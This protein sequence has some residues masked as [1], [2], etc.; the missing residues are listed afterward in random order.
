MTSRPYPPQQPL[1]PAT[2]QRLRALLTETES[3]RRALLDQRTHFER[4]IVEL[5]TE[6]ESIVT[7]AA[8]LDA[9]AARYRARLR[10]A[11]VLAEPPDSGV[12]QTGMFQAPE[13]ADDPDAAL[14]RPSQARD[15]M[16]PPG[17]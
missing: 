7:V 6:C 17:P 13:F 9:T 4:Q 14:V 3:H 11:G 5:K 2:A 10:E 12:P 15:Q 16:P 8:E 1:T